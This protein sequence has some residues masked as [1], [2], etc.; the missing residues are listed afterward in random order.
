[1]KKLIPLI[2]LVSSL[3]T[4]AFANELTLKPLALRD[5]SNGEWRVGFAGDLSSTPKRFMPQFFV[6]SNPTNW[7]KP[8]AGLALSTKIYNR[9]WANVSAVVGYSVNISNLKSLS[10]GRWGYGAEFTFKF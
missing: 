2:I 8:F 6:A 3:A 9:G 5:F 10:E 1:M 4:F 7:E